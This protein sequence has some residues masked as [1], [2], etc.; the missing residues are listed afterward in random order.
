MRC[1][2]SW[3]CLGELEILNRIR[4]EFKSQTKRGGHDNLMNTLTHSFAHS[5]LRPEN[6]LKLFISE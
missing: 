2:Y 4:F 5:W 1:V 3:Q 6:W